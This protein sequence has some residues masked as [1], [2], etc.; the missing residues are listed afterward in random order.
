MGKIHFFCMQFLYIINKLFGKEIYRL[1]KEWLCHFLKMPDFRSRI[2]YNSISKI[3]IYAIPDQ[4]PRIS[5]SWI[6]LPFDEAEGSANKLYVCTTYIIYTTGTLNIFL[7]NI[8]SLKV[9]IKRKLFKKMILPLVESS[10][11]VFVSISQKN[12]YNY[13]RIYSLN[14]KLNW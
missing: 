7:L 3:V 4:S 1:D 5:K 8:L 6:K 12:V 11:L 9:Y 2:V 14:L 10:A 13:K